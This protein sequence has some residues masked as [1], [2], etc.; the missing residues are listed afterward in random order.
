MRGVAA[1]FRGQAGACE[2]LGSPFMARLMTLCADRLRRG[3]PVADRILSWPGDASS[4]GDSVPLRLAG[5]LHALARAGHPALAAVYPPNAVSDEA[6]WAAVA[7]ALDDEA[8]FIDARLNRPPQTNEV[9]R[10]AA[11]IPALH[12]LARRFG[13][14]IRLIEIG[15]SA[16]LNLRAD[17]FRLDA[18]GT[19]FGP[20]EAALRLAPD[21]TG[22]APEPARI[23][24]EER[25]GLDIA[26]LDPARDAD[27]LLSYIWPDQP[28]R[29]AL[30][31][32]AIAIAAKTPARIVETD[33]VAWLRDPPP[34]SDGALTVL[35]H[36]IAWQYLPAPAR[37]EGDRLI[38]A[39]GDRATR[40]A[41]LARFAMEA[42]GPHAALTLQVWP[43]GG[44]IGL[45]RADYHGRW[46][47][48]EPGAAEALDHGT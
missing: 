7:G 37:A 10:A 31:A 21:W 17:R 11:L 2:R 15:C 8:A 32:A 46:V 12:L 24:I 47:S 14:S 45:G 23:R 30:T 9:R 35:F 28:D 5:A 1:A 13:P 26:P 16:G 18:G 40:T 41:P 33:A 20:A 25:I 27:R 36:T 48:W 3:G 22:P 44:I 19:A 43:R 34:L 39:L 6:F 29:I 42:A 4:K 38:A